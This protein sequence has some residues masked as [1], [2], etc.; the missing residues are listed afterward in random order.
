MW[1]KDKIEDIKLEIEIIKEDGMKKYIKNFFRSIWRKITRPFR[2]IKKIIDYIPLLWKDEDYD[3]FFILKM[4]QYKIKRTREHLIEHNIVEGVE[5]MAELM[6]EAE[7]IITRF[8]EEDYFTKEW[9]EHIEKY[10]TKW[11]DAGN[12]LSELYYDDVENSRKGTRELSEKTRKAKEED[13]NRLFDILKNHLLE[14]W[15]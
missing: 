2:R 11:K 8:T 7:D 9:L 5:K 3:D 4:L 10:P 6:K 13:W 12:G 1:I 15:D 14:W